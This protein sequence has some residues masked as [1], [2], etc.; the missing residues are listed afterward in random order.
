VVRYLAT[1]TT[2]G[3]LAMAAKVP[4]VVCTSLTSSWDSRVQCTCR[5]TIAVGG[6]WITSCDCLA[7]VNL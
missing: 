7:V 5:V 6:M 1:T 2:A 4:R 3:P